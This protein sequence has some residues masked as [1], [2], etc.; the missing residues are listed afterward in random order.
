MAQKSVA[1][2]KARRLMQRLGPP[3]APVDV[4]AIARELG[5]RVEFQASD[6]DELSGCI[7]SVPGGAV[8]GVNRDQA[9]TRQRFT[10]AH[11]LGHYVLHRRQLAD[12]H[13]QRGYRA[14]QGDDPT[15]IEANAF[16]AELLMPR[17]LVEASLRDR[18]HGSGLDAE[19]GDTDVIRELAREFDVS[20]Q[21]MTIRLVNLGYL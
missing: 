9:R 6:D 4:E 16:A 11:E 20:E 10:I 14:S 21:A 7:V 3:T 2:T 19:S 18:G 12:V 1:A 15:E 17:A 5:V 8:I 13:L